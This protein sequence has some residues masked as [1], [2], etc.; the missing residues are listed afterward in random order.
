M[1]P[2]PLALIFFSTQSRWRNGLGFTLSQADQFS[3][4]IRLHAVRTPRVSESESWL[5]LLIASISL[6]ILN[7]VR[8]KM[9][10]EAH[11]ETC[12]KS[13]IIHST[14]LSSMK[15]EN[16]STVQYVR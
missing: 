4:Q 7:D 11:T 14:F 2:R 1:S 8:T 6:L 16:A 10:P 3:F 12:K 13:A 9:A 15:D 5:S